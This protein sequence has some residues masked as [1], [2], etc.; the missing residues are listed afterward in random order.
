MDT[1][2]KK[3]LRDIDGSLNSN[4]KELDKLGKEADKGLSK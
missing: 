3:N 4:G 2:V 1:D